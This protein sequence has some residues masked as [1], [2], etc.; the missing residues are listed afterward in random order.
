MSAAAPAP[1]RQQQRRSQAAAPM[2]PRGPG[3]GR[4]KGRKEAERGAPGADKAAP[5]AAGS[6]A[7][8]SPKRR[9]NPAAKSLQLAAC[10]L[11]HS[12]DR[13]FQERRRL[14]GLPGRWPG[15]VTE[16]HAWPSIARGRMS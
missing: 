1:M 7:A 9:K 2:S 16:P 4:K 15:A 8:G 10:N 13:G 11:W 12:Q 14:D 5:A 6:G 3:Q